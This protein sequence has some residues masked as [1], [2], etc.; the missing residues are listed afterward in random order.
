MIAG[1]EEEEM[2]DAGQNEDEVTPQEE[3]PD[4]KEKKDS[5]EAKKETK[6]SLTTEAYVLLLG[7]KSDDFTKYV[8]QV[9]SAEKC[10]SKMGHNVVGAFISAR[11]L[12]KQPQSSS[13]A[14]NQEYLGMLEAHKQ[15]SSEAAEWVIWHQ[16]T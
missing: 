4:V 13:T 2:H 1:D 5:V 3:S 6:K 9:M 12:E 10:L 8:E 7:S 11:V 14:P 16:Q 15:L